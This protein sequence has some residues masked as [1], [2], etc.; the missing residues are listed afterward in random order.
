MYVVSD[1]FRN[2]QYSGESQF[3]GRLVI[4]N[5]T[6]PNE[7][8]S[9]ITIDNPIFD[10]SSSENNGVFYVGTFISQKVTVKFK[11]L[12]G[13]VVHSG[14]NAS[15]YISQ[16]VGNQ[17][18]EIPMGVYLVD[19]LAENYQETCEIDLLDYSVKFRNNVDYSSCFVD[20]KATIDDILQEVCDQCGVTLGTYPSVNGSI[21][22]SQF[23]ST[24]S[25]KQWISYIAELKGSNAKIGRD[26][27]LNLIPLKQISRVSI[28]ALESASWKLGEK[29]EI[30]KVLF[31]N[32]V[33]DYSKGDT[34]KNTLFIRAD[35]PFIY[36]QETIDN[37]YDEVEGFVCYSL[38]TRNY[39]DISLDAW[40]YLTYTLGNE[41]YY[42][43]NNNKLTFEMSIMSDTN[44]Q[45]SSKQQEV[46]T[47]YIGGNEKNQVKKL[48]TTVNALDNKIDIEVEDINTSMTSQEGRISNL[49][50][51][52]NSIATNVSSLQTLTTD[53]YNTLNSNLNDYKILTNDELGQINSKFNDYAT[54]ND[55]LS[56]ERSISTITT[57]T[58]TKTEVNTL[59]V[60]GSVKKLQTTSATLD[61][62]GMTYAKTN[63]PTSSN[64]NERGLTIVDSSN[65]PV[66]RAVY[67]DTIKN[68]IVD[69][70]R[71]QVHEYFIM[72]SHSRFEDY[73]DGT[74][75]F[76][77][78]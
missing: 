46:T 59:L 47:N 44:T 8:L 24:V 76:Y 42:T 57:D 62:N 60:D 49:E 56:I 45:I 14:D 36:D 22:T 5:V 41:T 52:T 55:L 32:G 61:E 71:H 30:S 40:D 66:L 48:R 20:N 29:Y 35:N 13:I 68:S 70:Y 38:Q 26:G 67:D 31:S 33:M 11:N 64:I 50:I 15:L 27:V 73:E 18:V 21:E 23:D 74:G 3:K 69:T 43:Y 6:V 53:Q 17:W 39:G 4:G 63:A 72:G 51:S 77:I 25:G 65:N 12:N 78:D 2:K 54:K 19:D 7:Q 34:T 9:K 75:C 1:A 10:S 37:I 58:Y 28:N 16:Y